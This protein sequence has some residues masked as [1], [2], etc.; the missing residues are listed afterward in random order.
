MINN[1]GD[2][3]VWE[4]ADGSLSLSLTVE[5]G[6][7]GQPYYVSGQTPGIGISTGSVLMDEFAFSPDG[8]R[9]AVGIGAEGAILGY[10]EC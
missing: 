5:R 7:D 1:V 9:L 3:L 2:V 4:T 8:D 10:P 6:S